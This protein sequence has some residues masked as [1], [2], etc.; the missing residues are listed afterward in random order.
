MWKKVST[1]ISILCIA[2]YGAAMVSAVVKLIIAFTE[3]RVIAE[4]EFSKLEDMARNA[5]VLGFSGKDLEPE[6]RDAVL[7]SL[8]LDAAIMSSSDGSTFAVEKPAKRVLISNYN[9]TAWTFN[10]R[11]KLYRSPF[12]A[13]VSSGSQ[14][15]L[16]VSAVA[17][18]I[19]NARLAG[20]LR[21][22]LFIVLLA[23][24]AAFL[25]MMLDITVF[26]GQKPAA[27]KRR[28]KPEQFYDEDSTEP[29]G[30]YLGLAQR[31]N[32]ELTEPSA[33]N[34]ETALLCVEWTN[35]VGSPGGGEPTTAK[36]I[37]EEAAVF[38]RVEHISAFKKGASGVFLVLPG[39]AFKNALKITRELHGRIMGNTAF[40]PVI[41]GLYI[42]VTVRGGRDIEPERLIIEAEKAAEKAKDD[43]SAPIV[44]FKADPK[45]Y[46]TFLKKR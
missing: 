30:P 46:K 10:V 41:S 15:A 14:R 11:W 22:T 9:N 38:F 25:T 26:S 40:K 32:E 21:E 44:A 20:I 16:T 8:A 27:P 12:F 1:I 45:K 28:E 39:V 19:D 2:V 4:R 31:L 35:P 34:A 24:T 5:G 13:Q 3:H 7:R 17:G 23:V 33:K 29:S 43:P 42:G 18:Y 36:Q 6:I 37:A